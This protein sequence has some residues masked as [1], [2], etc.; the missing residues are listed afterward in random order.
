MKS[1]AATEA[2]NRLGAIL[3]AA[4][5]EPI[6]IRRQ[7]RDIAVILSMADYDRLRSANVRAFLDLRNEVAAEATKA[8][9]TDERL[10]E[11]LNDDDDA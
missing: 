8:G 4:Q 10:A 6:V 5:R 7:D 3:D 2:K 1:I 11:L 9:L